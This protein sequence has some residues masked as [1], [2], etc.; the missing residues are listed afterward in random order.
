MVP[1]FGGNLA[2]KKENNNFNFYA[3]QL[4]MRIEMAFG[5]MMQKCGIQQWPL[6]NTL[7]AMKH[8]ICAIARLHNFCIDE[9]LKTNPNYGPN[10]SYDSLPQTKLAYMHSALEVEHHQ[11]LRSNEY[12]QWSFS[13]TSFFPND[14]A[15]NINWA[16]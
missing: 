12:P 3:S 7:G 10:N 15:T 8:I 5:L 9:R 6:T 11:I 2:L 14:C 13:S 16:C 1:I 4:R